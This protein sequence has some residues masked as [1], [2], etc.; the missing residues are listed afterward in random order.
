MP[1]DSSAE[2]DRGAGFTDS[3]PVLR[4]LSRLDLLP[5]LSLEGEL[6]FLE[7]CSLASFLYPFYGQSTDF[8]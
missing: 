1:E 3:L 5:R 2:A 4:P 7:R 6:T 8:C